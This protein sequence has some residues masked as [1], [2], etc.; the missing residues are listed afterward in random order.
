VKQNT[1][2]KK[3]ND[4]SNAVRTA[5]GSR[6]LAICEW[7]AWEYLNDP[8]GDFVSTRTDAEGNQY[9]VTAHKTGFPSISRAAKDRI[10]KLSKKDISDQDIRRGWEFIGK[11]SKWLAEVFEIDMESTRALFK[12]GKKWSN[13]AKPNGNGN[14]KKGAWERECDRLTNMETDKIK[15]NDNLKAMY[16]TLKKVFG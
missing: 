16:N 15:S 11:S 6:Q 5:T 4:L 3:R 14:G 1:Y 13:Q 7:I 12:D 9:C 2:T 8:N 10:I